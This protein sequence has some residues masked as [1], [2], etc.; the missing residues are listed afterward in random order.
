[1]HTASL[2]TADVFVDGSGASALVAVGP[3][4]FA[5]SLAAGVTIRLVQN[6]AQ[7]NTAPLRARQA[8]AALFQSAVVAHLTPDYLARHR[9]IYGAENG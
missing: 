8:A 6:K 4:R 9:A 5:C 1:M 2:I 3:H 7:S